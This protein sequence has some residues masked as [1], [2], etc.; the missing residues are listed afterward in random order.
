MGKQPLIL[1]FPGWACT[2]SIDAWYGFQVRCVSH[3]EQMKLFKNPELMR[4]LIPAEE[5]LLVTWSMGTW[6]G[7]EMEKI[8][9]DHPPRHWLALSPFIDFLKENEKVSEKSFELLLRSFD[10]T[11]ER[12]LELFQMRNG[13]MKLWCDQQLKDEEWTDLKKSLHYLGHHPPK[14]DHGLDIPVSAILGAQDKL[15][16]KKMV[17]SFCELFKD[18][19]LDVQSDLDHAIFY[20][21]HDEM[22]PR[23]DALV[24]A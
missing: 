7:F 4:Q 2:K 17:Q 16:S 10:R 6:M 15:V 12:T 13:A 3:L 5:W 1:C 21:E 8:W 24:Y 19:Q 20:E 9:G 14:L 22:R 23:V 18:A 11:P